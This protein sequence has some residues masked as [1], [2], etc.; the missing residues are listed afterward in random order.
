[1]QSL[2]E[3]CQLQWHMISIRK[4]QRCP[5]RHDSNDVLFCGL[6]LGSLEP[7]QD[8]GLVPLGR[9]LED[10]PDHL[11]AT[12]SKHRKEGV[13]QLRNVSGRLHQIMHKNKTYTVCFLAATLQPDT[14]ILAD[15]LVNK[16]DLV[17]PLYCPFRIF[18]VATRHEVPSIL[19][20]RLMQVPEIPSSNK[21]GIDIENLLLFAGARHLAK[22]QRALVAYVQPDSVL[23]HWAVFDGR[24]STVGQDVV[25]PVLFSLARVTV[26]D[27]LKVESLVNV[28]QEV[29]AYNTVVGALVFRKG[30]RPEN[31][32]AVV[33]HLGTRW[34]E[35]FVDTANR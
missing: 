8:I 13:A 20:Q 34:V 28:L 15:C 3:H 9:F 18:K 29:D 35:D 25:W 4:G 6:E 22:V 27:A 16:V 17:I 26:L 1:M 33:S 2:Q 12:T 14:S 23:D 31:W 32:V 24:N 7:S 11:S 10:G 5:R 30:L 19:E 21:Y